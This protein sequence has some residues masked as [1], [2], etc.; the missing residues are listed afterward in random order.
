MEWTGRSLE[1]CI[2]LDRALVLLPLCLALALQIDLS[3]SY[4]LWPNLYG[5]FETAMAGVGV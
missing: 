2:V 4:D 1:D 3:V 5:G